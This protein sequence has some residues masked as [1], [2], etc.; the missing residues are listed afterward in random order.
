[1]F[2]KRPTKLNIVTANKGEIQRIED[3]Q[4]HN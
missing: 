3:E 1:M 2:M 4:Q